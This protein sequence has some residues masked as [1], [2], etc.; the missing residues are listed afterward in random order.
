[1]TFVSSLVAAHWPLPRRKY[2]VT[3]TP[4]VGVPMR[5]GVVLGADLYQPDLF[6]TGGAHPRY[7][8]NLGLPGSFGAMTTMRA[9]QIR[10]HRSGSRLLLPVLQGGTP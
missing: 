4:G 3:K 8:R 6:V 5:D 10:I 9:A 1:M 7:A 2:R